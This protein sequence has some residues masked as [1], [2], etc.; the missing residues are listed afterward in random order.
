MTIEY[1]LIENARNMHM[2]MRQLV[3]VLNNNDDFIMN[4]IR[5]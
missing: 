1:Q 4:Y 2:G 3:D 5:I